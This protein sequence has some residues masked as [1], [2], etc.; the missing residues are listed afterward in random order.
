MKS[1]LFLTFTLVLL[2]LP[3][4]AETTQGAM[5]I[6]LGYL[7]TFANANTIVQLS[8]ALTCRYRSR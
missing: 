3:C 7:T 8:G 4:K 1:A 6:G 5:S 2:A